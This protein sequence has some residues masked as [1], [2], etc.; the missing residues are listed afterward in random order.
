MS[1][2]KHTTI[3]S[4]SSHTCQS[5]TEK[6]SLTAFLKGGKDPLF[7]HLLLKKTKRVEIKK[8]REKSWHCL[9]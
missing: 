6:D 3:S 4:R 9:K 5:V 7:H 8:L 1:K 2:A